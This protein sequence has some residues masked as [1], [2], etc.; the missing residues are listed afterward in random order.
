MRRVSRS[1][2]VWALGLSLV[3]GGCPSDT[4]AGNLPDATPDVTTD[5]VSADTGDTGSGADATDAAADAT[6]DA[7]P[8]IASDAT[9]DAGP[10]DVAPP[11]YDVPAYVPGGEDLAVDEVMALPGLKGV[12]RVLYDDRG[13]PHIYGD[14]VL[15]LARAQGYITARSRLFQMHT[16]RLAASGRLAEIS[17]PGAA[18]GDVLLRILGLRRVAEEMATQ[19][20]TQDPELFA[21]VQ[22]FADGANVRIQ[23]V[24]DGLVPAP[25]EVG[26]FGLKLDPWTVAD[27]MTIVR[28]QT[29][30]LSFGGQFDEYELLQQALGLKG[31]FDGTPLEGIERDVLRFD[32]PGRSPTITPNTPP[33]AATFNLDDVLADPFYAQ[34][35]PA[36]LGR[37]AQGERWMRELPHHAMR[38]GV[39]FGSNNW[40]VSGEH[41]ASHAALVANDTH[42]SLRNPA[43]FFQIQLSNTAAGGDLDVAGVNF[44]GAPG[45][46]LG[47]NPHAAW[48]ATVF[49]ADVTDTYVEDVSAD[50]KSVTFEGNQVPIEDTTETFLVLRPGDAKCE[51]LATLGWV[52]T[53]NPV[54]SAPD[55]GHCQLQVTMRRV[56]HHG[57]HHPLEPGRGRRRQA[58]RHDLALDGL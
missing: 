7:A 44:A 43:V 29:W 30:D 48:G 33:T 54:V 36:L 2:G 17:G 4:P 9:P 34:M 32:P 14:D 37:M 1:L 50:G 20:E 40:V 5:G 26:V 35:S 21:V 22:A 25:M 56:P 28:L 24:N 39:D 13:V 19:V 38:G 57:P 42:L 10:Q 55:D 12:V 31:A 16:L 51:D 41:T 15:D 23:Q 6:P 47:R 46:V 58:H 52:A 53:M 49:Y 3:A 8:D 45:I 18:Q 11:E 27:T